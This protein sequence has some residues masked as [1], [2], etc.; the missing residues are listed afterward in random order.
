MVRDFCSLYRQILPLFLP[1]MPTL[2]QSKMLIID[3]EKPPISEGVVVVDGDRI[4]EAG[5]HYGSPGVSHLAITIYSPTTG[6]LFVLGVPL[7]F[8]CGAFKTHLRVVVYEFSSVISD[9]LTGRHD[10]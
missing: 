5:E 7:L 3:P 2:I 9:Y 4:V 1:I 6:E 10:D 8:R